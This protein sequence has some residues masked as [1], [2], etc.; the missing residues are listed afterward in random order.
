[1]QSLASSCR[2]RRLN[3]LELEY[4]TRFLLVDLHPTMHSRHRIICLV[5]RQYVNLI[6]IYTTDLP[7]NNIQEKRLVE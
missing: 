1:M 5:C 7:H 4:N 6:I 3:V 2:A